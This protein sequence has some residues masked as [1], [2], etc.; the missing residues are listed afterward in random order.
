MFREL[1]E[2]NRDVTEA[3][4]RQTATSKVLE[5][6]SSSPTDTQPVFDLIAESATRLCEGQFGVVFRFDGELLHLV[7]HHGLTSE[8]VEVWGRTFPKPPN[9]GTAIGRALL[10]RDTI[11]IPD[12][13]VDPL[14]AGSDIAKMVGFRSLIAVPMLKHNRSLGGV[15]V[16]RKMAGHF[17]E[18]QADLVKTFANQAVIAIENVR[19]FQELEVRTEDLTRSVEQLT[20]LSE[21]GQ[22][23]SSTL[24]PEAVLETIVRRAVGLSGGHGGVIYEFDEA[25]EVFLARST[26]RISDA[27]LKAVRATPIRLGEGAVGRAGVTREPV[28]VIDTQIEGQ[29][30]APQVR[31]Q[32]LEE[33]LRALLA[34]PLVREQR[35][36]G[37]LV[38]VRREPGQFA[39]AVVA[40]LR[41]FAAQIRGCH[42]KRPV[43]P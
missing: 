24:D 28:E 25:E 14:F 8:H 13:E 9:E 32:V 36:L 20:A 5:V 10:R 35:L 23:V 43:V 19:L 29:T 30:V 33:G 40:L 3:L 27:H 38:I 12:V 34:I 31:E 21:I 39:P 11:E 26:H 22:V 18:A 37:G 4:E 16:A 42:P 1:E 17:P 7:G 2:R 41:T 15:V 6:I